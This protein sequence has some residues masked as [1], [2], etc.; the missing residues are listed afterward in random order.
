MQI[1]LTSVVNSLRSVV[2]QVWPGKRVCVQQRRE[3]A[4]TCSSERE[5]HRQPHRL[6]VTLWS[7]GKIT[8]LYI[9]NGILE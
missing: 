2:S 8:V 3:E 7:Q 5:G 1:R 6:L 9:H 4:S